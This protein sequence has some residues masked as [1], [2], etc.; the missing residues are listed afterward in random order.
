MLTV[1]FI[2]AGDLPSK[3][4]GNRRSL[5]SLPRDMSSRPVSEESSSDTNDA[6]HLQ[7]AL[8]CNTLASTVDEIA[9]LQKAISASGP[10]EGAEV[11]ISVLLKEMEAA[12]GVAQGVESKLDKLLE[13][14]EGLLQGLEVN[15]SNI[16]LRLLLSIAFV[17]RAHKRLSKTR[18]ARM[19]LVLLVQ[20]NLE[21]HEV[22]FIYFRLDMLLIRLFGNMVPSLVFQLAAFVNNYGF[23]VQ[24]SSVFK[25]RNPSLQARH[26]TSRRL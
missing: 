26:H 25:F 15:Q 6:A 5:W 2:N 23:G 1:C 17:F 21:T 22:T 24:L 20:L 10:T 7:D 19:A 3:S 16:L 4:K 14:I 13:N 9:L 11:D 8:S 12:D 18:Q